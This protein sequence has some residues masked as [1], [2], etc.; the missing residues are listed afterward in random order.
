MCVLCYP[1][2]YSDFDVAK[3]DNSIKKY[4]NVL[5][6]RKLPNFVLSCG[7]KF[8]VTPTQQFFSLR[9]VCS[10]KLSI[11]LNIKMDVSNNKYSIYV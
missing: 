1:L 6:S 9:G 11:A 3:M 10:N 5:K 2:F 7:K 8:Y 4:I